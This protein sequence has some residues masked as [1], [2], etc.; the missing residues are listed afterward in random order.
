M[1]LKNPSLLGHSHGGP[2]ALKFDQY[3]PGVVSKIILISA[4][5][6]FF[7]S[8]GSIRIHC[9]TRYSAIGDTDNLNK[10]QE[11]FA[12]LN[13]KPSLENEIKAIG[14]IFALGLNKPCNLYHPSQPTED[15]EKNHDKAKKFRVEVGL[16]NIN[17]PMPNFV[18]N[19]Q[20]IYL[21]QTEWV[22]ANADHIFGIYGSEDG[23]FTPDVLAD[24]K[25]SLVRNPSPYRFQLIEGASHAI[26]IDQQFQFIESIIKD[27]K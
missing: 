18:I 1:E 9:S 15:G 12:T 21:N 7:K 8:M 13:G 17:Y 25:E 4:P 3:Y 20:Y 24:I 14:E 27:L 10:L 11:Q 26:Y 6:D 2:I 16:T 22:K 5:I 19:E 23:L